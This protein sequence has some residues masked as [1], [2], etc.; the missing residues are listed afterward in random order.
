MMRAFV[1]GGDLPQGVSH[2]LTIVCSWIGDVTEG[3]TQ[4]TWQLSR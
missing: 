4:L 1:C 3:A 2:R